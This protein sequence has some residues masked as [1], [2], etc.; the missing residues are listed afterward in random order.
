[1][2]KIPINFK[3]KLKSGRVVYGTW[4]MLSSPNVIDVLGTTG[5][6]FVIFD[7]E[8]GSM[9][10]ETAENMVRAAESRNITAIIRVTELSE[11]TILRALETNCKGILV[12]HIETLQD[13][14]RVVKAARYQPEGTRGLSPY[15]RV[16]AFDHRNLKTSLA[17]INTELFV[18][19]LVEGK[20]G[21][22]E[23][24]GIAKVQGI[25]MIYLGV[26]DISQAVGYPGELQHPA[27][28]QAVETAVKKIR[29]QKKIAGTF[30]RDLESTQ[31]YTQMGVQ[32]IAY[33]VDSFALKDYY[34]QFLK[35]DQPHKT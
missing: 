7:M 29:K 16:H 25:D 24:E 1:M 18:G 26:Y 12:P 32:F 6:D 2:A 34:Q 5:L 28:L 14:K 20:T 21:I 30:T 31:R 9:S 4:S 19:V 10:F 35:K 13:A 22:A 33:L 17:R 15:T 8:H 3:T 11:A 27:V 23:I